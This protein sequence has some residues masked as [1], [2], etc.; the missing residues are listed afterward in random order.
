M[1]YETLPLAKVATFLDSKRRPVKEADR[2]EGPYPYYGANGQQGWIDGFLFDEPLILLAEDGGHFDD[3]KRGIAY[4]IKGKT[5]V[6]NH[7]HVLKP[8]ERMDFRY[9]LHALKN[10]DVRAYI[11]GSTRAKLTK[12]GAARIPVQVP[13]LDEQR[14]IASILDKAEDLLAKRRA[15]LDLLDQLPQATFLEMFGDP[16]T[17]PKG[18][19]VR[20]LRDAADGKYGV[21]AGPFGSA[22]KKEDYVSHGYRVYGQEQ[23]IGGS[24]EIGDY[25]IDERK[26]KKLESCAVKTGDLLMSLVGS[27]GKVLVVPEGIEPGIINPRL[28][29]ITPNSSLLNSTFLAHQIQFPTTQS[30]LS[31]VAHGG[32]M[33]VLNAGILK[34]LITVMPPIDLQRRFVARVEAIHRAKAAHRSALEK[35]DALFSTLQ[36]RAFEQGQTPPEYMT[37]ELVSR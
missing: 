36:S 27:F 23:V 24:F 33:G 37:R 20:P 11:N 15:A 12:D 22:I 6:N 9:L 25:Y 13:P 32:T 34:D 5:W 8:S 31:S 26:Y 3:P 18:W 10:R 19:Q 14:R 7:A 29:K 4:A 30:R 28:L 1:T 17:N 16:A 35:L 2:V 21:K